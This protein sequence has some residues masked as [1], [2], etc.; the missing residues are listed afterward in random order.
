MNIFEKAAAILVTNLTDD[1]LIELTEEAGQARWALDGSIED[2]LLNLLN[3][4]LA[5]RHPELFK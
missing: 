4:V 2:H 1:E 5:Q 3:E